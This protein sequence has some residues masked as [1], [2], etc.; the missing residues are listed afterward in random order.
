MNLFSRQKKAA[1]KKVS[2]FIVFAV[3]LFSIFSYLPVHA[4]SGS[5]T[6]FVAPGSGSYSVGQ[7]FT[8]S[9]VASS[10]DEMNAAEATLSFN[11]SALSVTGMSK[12]GSVFTLWTEEPSYSNSAGSIRFGGGNPSGFSGNSTLLKIT[13]KA[14]AE[15]ATR[16]SFSDGAVLAA[17]GKGT[18]IL[19]GMNPGNYTIQAASA[20]P[21]ANNNNNNNNNN[22]SG[23]QSSGSTPSAPEVTSSTHPDQEAW[24]NATTGEFEWDLPSGTT[25]TR[26][27]L[28][29][30]ED[31]VPT[32]RHAPA[33][34]SR[35]IEDIE[36]GVW[37]LH[38]RLANSAG[39]GGI[40]TYKI[41]VDTE[42]PNDFNTEVVSEE[43]KA[44][45]E[46]KFESID[47]LSGIGTYEI[48]VDGGEPIVVNADDLSNGTYKFDDPLEQG[49]HSIV[50]SAI[51]K[52]G[53]KK[54]SGNTIDLNVTE[55]VESKKSVEP[56]EEGP[57]FFEKYGT[58]IWVFIFILII[59]GLAALN[60]MQKKKLEQ[61]KLSAIKDV[62]AV[63]A[64]S[65]KVLSALRDEAE[66]IFAKMDGKAGLSD[67]EGASY[68]QLK[69]A[70]DISEELIGREI[71][72]I[73]K[74][75]K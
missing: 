71:D 72:D 49:E 8:I 1:N 33:I 56:V 10:S 58:A 64:T 37:Y 15:G 27:L 26:L 59:L 52:A 46:L 40:A 63:R 4:Q 41:Q 9:V 39:L 53:N 48:S 44:H 12:S 55:V 17:D 60:I 2:S 50:V 43:G 69:E 13:F 75:F 38:V 34:A 23:G 28:S 65:E 42:A 29:Q 51:D 32:V 7:T 14:N 67:K 66:D 18:N 22:N 35:T 6:L 3:F 54:E 21:P 62:K 36:D 70:I 19:S 73:E 45:P 74:L 24:Y 25:S 61:L 31:D 57:G 30:N 68:D 16:V 47:S 5:A 11:P 20:P